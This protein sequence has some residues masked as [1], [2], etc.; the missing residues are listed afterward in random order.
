MPK[1]TAL[2]KST[3]LIELV[4]IQ[5]GCT[6][7]NTTGPLKKCYYWKVYTES[8]A[9]GGLFSCQIHNRNLPVMYITPSILA[10]PLLG[11]Q[12]IRAH[13]TEYCGQ[14]HIGRDLQV[15]GSHSPMLLQFPWWAQTV[16]QK[17]ENGSFWRGWLHV[18]DTYPGPEPDS[19][20]TY[21][22]YSRWKESQL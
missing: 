16:T 20:H 1:F 7:L 4:K 18:P 9:V 15:H 6:S 8:L 12:A 19:P 5:Y 10:P 13:H 14:V 2:W 21:R 17:K 22:W 3:E 11:R